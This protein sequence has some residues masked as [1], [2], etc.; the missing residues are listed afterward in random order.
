[1]W[2]ALAPE[3]EWLTNITVGTLDRPH[4]ARMTRHIYADMQLPWYDP[5]PNLPKLTADEGDLLISTQN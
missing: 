1:M 4:E 3:D 2:Q 5:C